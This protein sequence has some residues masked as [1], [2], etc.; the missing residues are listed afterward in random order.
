MAHPRIFRIYYSTLF[1]SFSIVLLAL[2]LITP[3]DA[4]NQA[5]S[6][7]QLYNVFVIAGGYLLTLLLALIIYA[8]RLYTNRTVIAGI[9]KTWIP[10]EKGD[11]RN[12]VR[13][14]IVESLSRNA[15]IAWNARPRVLDHATRPAQDAQAQV[16][17]VNSF[18][19]T[20]TAI[21]HHKLL[22]R[23]RVATE[24]GEEGITMPPHHLVWGEIAHDGWSSPSSPDLPNLQYVTVILELPHL[25]EAKAVSLAPPD[26]ASTTTPPMPDLRAVELLQRPA[27]MSLRD[28]ISHLI[29]LD[30]LSPAIP[31]TNFLS[32]YET[33]RFSS[34]P[35]TEKEF[36]ELM[37]LFA[38]ILRGMTPLNPAILDSLD[39]VESD[40][41]ADASSTTTS[42][43]LAPHSHNRSRSRSRS[44]ASSHAASSRSGSEGTIRTAPSRHRTT[45][46]SSTLG[47]GPGFSTAPAT[48]KSKKRDRERQV[49]ER[50]PSLH[51]FAQ[52]RRP[53]AVSQASSSSGL[54]SASGESVIKL[55]KN[56]EPGDLPYTLQLDS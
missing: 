9:P 16:V 33:A 24:K 23:I 28:Y 2:L 5:L 26:A 46:R 34:Q 37:R 36:R 13:K 50:S 40:I 29:S 8:S 38:D 52:T 3:A 47:P 53:Y 39:A 15:V 12:S 18:Q 41:D 14:M 54:R 1:T 42:E 56:S 4:I 55:N 43:G 49:V 30:I 48:P 51:S 11:V 27:A 32:A 35:R 21:K 7:N 17:N 44:L 25:I 10:V 45:T 19:M 6:N 31:V 20:G 22:R